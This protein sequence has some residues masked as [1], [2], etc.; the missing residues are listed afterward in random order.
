L[1]IDTAVQSERA[2]AS[3]IHS[4]RTLVALLSGWVTQSDPQGTTRFLA[5]PPQLAVPAPPDGRLGPDGVDPPP[6][7][8]HQP[9]HG[10]ANSAN[11]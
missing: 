10:D 2:S 5:H 7:A 8:A 1:I 9:R 6:P 11:T 3:T 4:Q